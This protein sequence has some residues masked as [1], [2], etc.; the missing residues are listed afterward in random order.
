MSDFQMSS[1]LKPSMSYTFYHL[2]L[3]VLRTA[4]QGRPVG[5]LEDQERHRIQRVKHIIDL[6]FLTTTAQQFFLS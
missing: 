1:W 3:K 4:L 2:Q 6:I 5:L